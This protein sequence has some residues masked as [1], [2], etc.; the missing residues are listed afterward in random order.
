ML[1]IYDIIAKNSDRLPRGGRP[2]QNTVQHQIMIGC[3][4]SQTMEQVVGE[5]ELLRM[6]SSFFEKREIGF[7]V[8]VADG[9]YFYRNG[10]FSFE[11]TLIITLIGDQHF[12]IIQLSKALSMFMNQEHLL[13]VRSQK[14]VEYESSGI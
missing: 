2:L 13:I 12:D 8:T 9:G 11:K 10:T 6:I 7:S 14:D 3:N 4:D 1:R 5:E